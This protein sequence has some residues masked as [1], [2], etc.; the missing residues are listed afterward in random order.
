M[1]LVKTLPAM[2]QLIQADV[3]A[4]EIVRRDVSRE[5]KKRKKFKAQNHP[6]SPVRPARQQ[7]PCV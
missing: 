5:K 2:W 4:R 6:H 3:H 1:R 7:A